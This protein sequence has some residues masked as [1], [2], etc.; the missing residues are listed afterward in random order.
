VTFTVSLD[1]LFKMQTSVRISAAKRRLVLNLSQKMHLI[2]WIMK[3]V[4]CSE[5]V[6]VCV[7]AFTHTHTHTISSQKII[8]VVY[9]FITKDSTLIMIK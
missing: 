3:M 5:C 4:L 2:S 9:K 8:G 6:C 1:M 7:S